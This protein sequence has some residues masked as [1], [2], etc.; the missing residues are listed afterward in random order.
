M[1]QGH[2]YSGINFL[3]GIQASLDGGVITGSFSK[4]KKN[5]HNIC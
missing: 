2:S 1:L 4:K 5:P 3:R